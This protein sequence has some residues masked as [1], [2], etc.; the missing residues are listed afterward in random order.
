MPRGRGRGQPRQPTLH[1][2]DPETVKHE[3]LAAGFE[4]VGSSDTP[5]PAGRSAH[6]ESLR[7]F[8][9]AAGPI[10][11]SLNFAS[12]A[13]PE[14]RADEWPRSELC[15]PVSVNV[16]ALDAL[17]GKGLEARK[18]MTLL[19]FSRHT[20]PRC[21]RRPAAGGLALSACVTPPPR[22][23]AIAPPPPHRNHSSIPATAKVPEQTDRDRYECHVGL[24]MR[25][26]SIR[27]RPDA[28]PTSDGGPARAASR[29]PVRRW[30]PSAAPYS[31]PFLRAREM[32]GAGLV[33]GAATGAIV[34]S[35]AD[36]NAQAQARQAQAQINQ[37]TAAKSRPI[38]RARTP[39]A[40]R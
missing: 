28:T 34:G 25:R 2:I 20:R 29:A 38:G 36:A 27:S 15:R 4:F 10:N 26:A 12:R 14:G 9:S 37:E 5:A 13:N 24:C 35:A 8:R 16:V 33:L 21:V 3:V 19:D 18:L 7:P 23:V 22:T 40:V 30:A 32:R 31:A 1:R 11:S 6:G 17:M 39:I